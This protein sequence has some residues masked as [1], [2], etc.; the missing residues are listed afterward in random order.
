MDCINVME[1]V[2]LSL[3]LYVVPI[4]V[5]QAVADKPGTP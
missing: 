5:D 3:R 2:A 4:A 1:V